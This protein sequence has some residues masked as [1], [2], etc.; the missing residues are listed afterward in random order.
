M[1]GYSTA[2]SVAQ[3]LNTTLT[4]AGTAEAIA[5]LSAAEE[6]IDDYT[7]R[8][9]LTGV[10]TTERVP[11][12]G[13]YVYLRDTPVAS[14]GTVTARYY[15]STAPT[16]MVLNTDYEEADLT[17]GLLVLSSY[18]NGLD[19][20]GFPRHG[21]GYDY[22][23]VSYTPGTAVPARVARAATILA[24]RGMQPSQTGGNLDVVERTAGDVTWR[25]APASS[26]TKAETLPAEVTT[27]LAPLRRGLIA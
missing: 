17:R 26:G 16:A 27:L 13:P 12:D 10:V 11:L 7:G 14:V 1:R 8:A 23:Q 4:A 9:W 5:A 20:D 2:G 24:A 25:V 19:A 21:R 6:T 22:L 15:G 3:Y 18:G